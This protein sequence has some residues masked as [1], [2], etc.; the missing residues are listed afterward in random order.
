M[1]RITLNSL[2]FGLLAITLSSS[3]SVNGQQ[4]TQEQAPTFT[5]WLWPVAIPADSSTEIKAAADQLAKTLRTPLGVVLS[6]QNPGCAFWLEVGSWKPN[7]STPGY[8]IL[9]QPG[10]GLIMATDVKQLQRA[11]D[12]LKQKTRI[13]NGRTEL[14]VGLITSYPIHPAT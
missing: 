12:Q 13:R 4:P 10:G 5:S 14:P 11:I 6:S 8:I 7:P 3:A 9:I 1:R 2:I